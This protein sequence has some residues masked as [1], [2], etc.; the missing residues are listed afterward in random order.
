MINFIKNYFNKQ[1]EITVTTH[2]TYRTLFDRIRD[3]HWML[4]YIRAEDDIYGVVTD[5]RTEPCLDTLHAIHFNSN[6]GEVVLITRYCNDHYHLYYFE[7]NKIP[8]INGKLDKNLF[9]YLSENFLYHLEASSYSFSIYP[10]FAKANLT[11]KDVD[12]SI[13][14]VESYIERKF[15]TIWDMINFDSKQHTKLWSNYE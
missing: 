8:L 13:H 5:T 9:R 10:Y 4:D 1:E 11:A 6:L 14:E 7:A 2:V 3:F 12:L 15:G